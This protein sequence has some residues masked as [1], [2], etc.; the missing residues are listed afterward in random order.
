MFY[1]YAHHVQAWS[2]E[3]AGSPGIETTDVREPPCGCWKSNP[4][5]LQEQQMFLTAEP[6]LSSP[7]L[8]LLLLLLLTHAFL[9]SL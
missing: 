3:D 2:K 4:G 8:L 1:V 9:H 6:S 5:P 7:L